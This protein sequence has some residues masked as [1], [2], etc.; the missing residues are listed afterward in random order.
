[1][2]GEFGKPGIVDDFIKKYIKGIARLN[3]LF[4]SKPKKKSKICPG[5]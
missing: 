5:E 2:S 3:N 4:T 1:M